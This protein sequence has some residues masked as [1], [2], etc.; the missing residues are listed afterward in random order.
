M[1]AGL[2]LWAQWTLVIGMVLWTL[3][4]AWPYMRWTQ[5]RINATANA[6]E[7]VQ[8]FV[9]D[10]LVP[11]VKDARAMITGAQTIV[12]DL[13][14]QNPK[15]ILEFIDRLEKDGTIHKLTASIEQIVL[16]FKTDGLGE[17]SGK[18]RGEIVREAE[19]IVKE[20]N[21]LNERR[22]HDL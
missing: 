5:R 16:K 3:L 9:E 21:G 2:P 6:M 13:K 12:N 14:S 8:R 19:Q 15:R 17:S 10:E 7:S 22:D 20:E 1:I 4:V 18:T 11:V